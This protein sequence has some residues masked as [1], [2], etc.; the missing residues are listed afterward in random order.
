M[1]EGLPRRGGC[2]AAPPA[3][4]TELGGQGR[5]SVAL[6]APVGA[7]SS[8][9]LV[10]DGEEAPPCLCGWV[11]VPA[12]S[13]EGRSCRSFSSLAFSGVFGSFLV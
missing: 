12:S 9:V 11:K 6:G 5:G 4:V 8:L 7:P 2:P 10:E 1:V 3:V 13:L